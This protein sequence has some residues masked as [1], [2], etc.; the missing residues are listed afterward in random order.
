[1]AEVG[2]VDVLLPDVAYVY[3]YDV[4]N[5]Y[6]HTICLVFIYMLKCIHV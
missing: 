4:L 3:T 2:V 5:K 1:V 6:M